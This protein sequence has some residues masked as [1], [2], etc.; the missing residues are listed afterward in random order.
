MRDYAAVV[1]TRAGG[2][3]TPMG[4]L[5]VTGNEARFSYA[6]AFL[7]SGLPGLG[8]LYPCPPQTSPT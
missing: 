6:E 5:F 1:W 4:N 3:P 8:I 7:D 2:M